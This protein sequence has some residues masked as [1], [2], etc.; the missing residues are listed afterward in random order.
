VFVGRRVSN[1]GR[2]LV[3]HGAGFS[4]VCE[5]QFRHDDVLHFQPRQKRGV[6][7][8]FGDTCGGSCP[9]LAILYSF[10][11]RSYV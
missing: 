1:E 2:G 6:G 5:C 3:E 9:A 8:A 10:E 4:A 11:R 7:F